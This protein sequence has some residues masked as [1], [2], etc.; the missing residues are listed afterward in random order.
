MSRTGTEFEVRTM[1]DG[2]KSI[3]VHSPFHPTHDQFCEAARGGWRTEQCGCMQRW[4]SHDERCT[5][6]EA[7]S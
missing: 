1:S 3:I 6:C 5:C 4:L 7:G 2:Y